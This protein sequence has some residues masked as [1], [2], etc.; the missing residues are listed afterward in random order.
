MPAS[1][2]SPT[3]SARTWPASRSAPGRSTPATDL[4]AENLNANLGDPKAAARYTT[5]ALALFPL[6]EPAHAQDALFVLWWARAM[7]AQAN[8]QRSAG[9]AAGAL[10]WRERQ[11]DLQL[12]G[13]LRGI[14]SLKARRELGSA[15]VG[16]GQ[17]YDT[18]QVASLNRPVEAMKAFEQ[19][20]AVDRELAAENPQESTYRY[21]QGTLAGARMLVLVKQGRLAE[22]APLG[23]QAVAL[24]LVSLALEPG[25]VAMPDGLATELSNLASVLLDLGLDAEALACA[26]E[27]R[28]LMQA[29]E[30]ADPSV[31]TWAKRRQV[32]ALHQGCA[33]LA[34]GQPAEALPVLREALEPMAN[35]SQGMA[36]RRRGWGHAALAEARAALGQADAAR[37]ARTTLP[38]A[39]WRTS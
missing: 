9:D 12:A 13:Q 29:L 21:Q 39:T 7:R 38:A 4:Q 17:A 20:D 28:R 34:N 14:N 30:R 35:A 5:Q 15:L 33:L 32:F 31:P 11:R 26:S 37:A 36:L 8:N 19:A 1:T 6:G 16:I 2:P 18:V 23:R 22:A 27:A 3:T 24:R 25:N 10:Q